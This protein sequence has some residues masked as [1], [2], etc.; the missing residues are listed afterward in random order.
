MKKYILS[1]FL[2]VAFLVPFVGQSATLAELQT[3]LLQIQAAISA[4]PQSQ[5]ANF[6]PADT[7]RDYVISKGELDAYNKLY[8]D[9]KVTLS[10]W[11]RVTQFFNSGGYQ[12]KA[13]TEDGFAPGQT[14]NIL[15]SLSPNSP[16]A[17]HVAI[18]STV[19]TN[20]VNLGVFRLRSQRQNSVLNSLTFFIGVGDDVN[21]IVNRERTFSNLKLSDGNNTYGATSFS[22][23]IVT[24]NNL[25]IP[26]PQD[27]SKDLT[28]IATVAASN[29]S[30]TASSSL[31]ARTINAVDSNYNSALI[32]GLPMNNV[33]IADVGA[34]TIVLTIQ[35]LI[36]VDSTPITL[37]PVN[38]A[39]KPISSYIFNFSITLTNQ[40][41]NELYISKLAENVLDIS[42]TP[43][44]KEAV[45]VVMAPTPSLVGDT[46]SA[47]IIPSG[48]SRKFTFSGTL[49][50]AGN[51]HYQELTVI[52][53]KYGINPTVLNSNIFKIAS[54]QLSTRVYFSS[55]VLPPPPVV[56]SPTISNI[57]IAGNP[58]AWVRATSRAVTWQTNG[59][60]PLV[61]ILV[62]IEGG[63][64]FSA[65]KGIANTGSVA[66]VRVGNNIPAGS[67]A[68]I[69]IR[70]T[71]NN[72]IVANSYVFEVVNSASSQAQINQLASAVESLRKLIE[73]YR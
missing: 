70:Q 36:T 35:P 9:K 3:Q 51:N 62:C 47:Y 54:G 32:N 56:I 15:P 68:F 38:I 40:G 6:H 27:I 1:F 59:S 26:L 48:A 52:G 71:G 14:A 43:L 64:C 5:T 58:T 44:N 72:S 46:L 49:N 13:G 33:G 69:R 55:S 20:N 65:H 61:D 24:F 12:L 29:S 23:G 60:I 63:S 53:I 8:Q 28:L 39:N 73:N 25:N 42:T 50:Q 45:T 37:S 7:N 10:Q 41:N 19:N 30:L 18:S 2:A 66:G 31:R 21:N 4:I 17:R 22:A 34:A 16:V 67:R 57:S 11:L